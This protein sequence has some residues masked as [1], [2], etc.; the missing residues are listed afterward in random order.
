MKKQLK[1]VPVYHPCGKC[2]LSFDFCRCDTA[3]ELE[4]LSWF[5]QNCDFGP[6]HGDV[7]QILKQSF[8]KTTGRL[9]PEGY[10]MEVE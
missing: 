10:E 6:A 9:L 1:R 2:E 4:F 8:V 3:T 5:Y 7:M